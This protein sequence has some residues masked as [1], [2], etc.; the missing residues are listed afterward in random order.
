LFGQGRTP[1]AISNVSIWI[2]NHQKY[3]EFKLMAMTFGFW[4]AYIRTPART[5]KLDIGFLA[6]VVVMGEVFSEQTR[7]NASSSTIAQRMW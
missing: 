7:K 5:A 1:L 6:L 2:Q 3:L 4:L